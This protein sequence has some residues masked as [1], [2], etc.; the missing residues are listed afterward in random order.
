MMQSEN[1]LI[2]VVVPVY[3]AESYL[4]ICLDSLLVQTYSRFELLLVNDGSTDRSGEICDRYATQD[5]RIRVIHQKNR[6]VSAS[7]NRGIECATGEYICFADAD[8]KVEEDYLKHLADA[9]PAGA[10]RGVIASGLHFAYSEGR[11]V[12]TFTFPEKELWG[13]EMGVAFTEMTIYKYGYSASKLYNLSLIREKNVCFNEKIHHAEDA[14]FM[15]D[16]LQYADYIRFISVA[17][18]IYIQYEGMSLSRSNRSYE[19]EI[20]AFRKLSEHLVAA[21]KR[22]GYPLACLKKMREDLAAYLILALPALYR[23]PLALKRKDRLKALSGLTPEDLSLLEICY[24]PPRRLEK[25][26]K[27]MLLARRIKGYDCYMKFL[28]CI[29]YRILPKFRK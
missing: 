6:G 7:R 3:N 4:S 28:F 12:D 25:I 23:P 19:T 16:Y 13:M 26:G 18:Y 17:D 15:L 8:D 2:S 27:K 21:Q 11:I 29:R 1:Y 9:L 10:A 20:I 5:K 24:H 14:L 22:Y